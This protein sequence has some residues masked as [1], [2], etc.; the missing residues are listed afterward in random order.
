M[1]VVIVVVGVLC[2]VMGVVL[3]VVECCVIGVSERV[4]MD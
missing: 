4:F 3:M 2:F 1:I